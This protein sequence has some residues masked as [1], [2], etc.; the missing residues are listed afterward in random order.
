LYLTYGLHIVSIST[1][2]MLAE[3]LESAMLSVVLPVLGVIVGW[4][5][6]RSWRRQH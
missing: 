5:I 4:G 1:G 6:V 2:M 3:R